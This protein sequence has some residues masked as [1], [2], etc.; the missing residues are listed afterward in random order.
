VGVVF[1]A[2]PNNPT[3]QVA[4]REAVRA[5]AAAVPAGAIVFVDEAYAD[6]SGESALEDL[7]AYKNIIIGRTFAKA[8]GLAALRIGAVMG[9]PDVLEPMRRVVPPYTLNIAA[10]TGLHA[11]LGDTEYVRRYIRDVAESKR[12]LYQTFDRLGFTYWPSA[13]N[14]VLVRTG[15]DTA[16]VVREMAA[17]GIAVRDRSHQPGCK[18][19]LRITAGVLE[20]TRAAIAALEEV[21]CGAR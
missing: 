15:D 20:H 9:H 5:I 8:Y 6:F 7:D 14:F 3:G 2:S 18:G 12:L 13:G 4:P 11:A 1:L 17:R 21:L 10:V 16:R 19:C